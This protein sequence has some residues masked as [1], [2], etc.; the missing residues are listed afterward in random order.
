MIKIKIDNSTTL[1]EGLT[2]QKH[3]ELKELL[4]YDL[5]P[6]GNYF[7]KSFRSTKRTLL[8]R[9]GDFPTGLLPRVLDW[10]VTE[11]L[12]FEAQDL[13]IIPE[14]L[15]THLTM[16]LPHKPY[17]EQEN[18]ALACLNSNRGIVSAPTGSGKSVIIA[19]IIEKLQVKTLV[20]VPSLELKKQL[21]SSLKSVFGDDTVGPNR[22]IW[23]ENVDALDPVKVY[24]DYGAVIID[25]FHHS[26]SKTYRTLN[27]KSFSKIFYRF[28]LTATPFRSNDNESLL[29]ESVLSEIIYKISYK[30]ALFE[31]Y[32]VPMNAFYVEVPN[33]LGSKKIDFGGYAPAYS[34]LITNNK[35]RNELIQRILL[36]SHKNKLSTLCLVKEIKHGELISQNDAFYFVTGQN[37]E[38]HLIE[39]F[40]KGD[41]STLVAT[42]GVM[43]EGVDSKA[44]EYV[45][46]ACPVKSRN[47]FMQMVG[48][49]FRKY[50]G[51]ESA[52]IILLKDTS[53]KYFRSAF[54]E[55]VKIL[56]EEYDVI[57]EKLN[58]T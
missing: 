48:R 55:Q 37:D 54:R 20:I 33:I 45:I 50:P 52:T 30:T 36:N 10:V 12:E 17:Q 34:K 49:A 1:I 57:P 22:S 26:A 58:I 19:L 51:K 21:S 31:K 29:L 13:R 24:S 5:N 6:T 35:C 18:A 56:L 15:T 32:I 46:I 16:S 40:A 53:H 9:K 14:C 4:S 39:K 7:A 23:V 25:E 38:R 41:I 11:N 47:L 3:S 43:G 27:K 2:S 42:T 8:G 44:C 28:G